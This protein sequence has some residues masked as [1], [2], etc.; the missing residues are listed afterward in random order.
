MLVTGHTGFKGAWLCL[1]LEQLGAEVM[2]L[3]LPPA[4][5]SLFAR[6]GLAGRWR[7]WMVDIRDRGALASS[8]LEAQ[9]ELVIHMAA[10][11]LVSVGY[12]DPILTME[13]N[14]MGTAYVL[15]EV[16][17]SDS[18]SGC[19]VITTDK[20][21]LP[22]REAHR[23]VESD[24]LG[25]EDPYAASKSSAEHVIASWRRMLSEAQ[26]AKVASVRAG[27]VIGGGDFAEN[28]LLPDLVRAF[29]AG[30][31]ALVRQPGFTRPWQH[32]L[33]PLSGYLLAGSALLT[34]HDL[35]AAINFGPERE[36]SVGHVA[37]LAV[38]AWGGSAEWREGASL[39]IHEAPLLALDSSLARESLG[40]TPTWDTQE[41]VT[42]TVHWWQGILSGD[43][44]VES[45]L[46]DIREFE[47]DSS[48]ARARN[49]P[50]D[51]T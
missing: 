7:E 46:R 9:P 10:Q 43:D 47:R 51:T 40:W 19:L 18:V 2:G 14:V 38:E 45:C 33:D 5:D 36:H 37:D 42:R 35:P 49:E 34:G 20:V 41:A 23:H 8:F 13:T 27:N 48:A 31:P 24:P 16:R 29:S 22:R 30:V 11:P 12:R 28:R 4:Q 3:S 44:P 50:G 39:G 21:Y 1:Q 32:V 17:R 6:A 25:G 26:G 15:E